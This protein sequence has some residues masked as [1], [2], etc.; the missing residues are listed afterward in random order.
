MPLPLPLRS[1]KLPWAR[2]P[3]I[4]AM[5]EANVLFALFAAVVVLD[6]GVGPAM[7]IRPPLDG[8]APG[9]R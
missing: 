5:P 7:V 1:S 9:D 2:L 3:R 6:V 4:E 8:A